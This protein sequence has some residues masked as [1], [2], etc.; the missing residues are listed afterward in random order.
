[1]S[2]TPKKSP[3]Q[4]PP[5]SGIGAGAPSS[6][7]RSSFRRLSDTSQRLGQTLEALGDREERADERLARCVSRRNEL[8][9]EIADLSMQLSAL[10]AANDARAA[11]LDIARS[12]GARRQR[13]IEELEAEQAKLRERID[14]T[15]AATRQQQRQQQQTELPDRHPPSPLCA[16][17]AVSVAVVS[18]VFALSSAWTVW[19]YREDMSPRPLPS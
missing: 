15:A 5:G 14:A 2:Q 1:M 11:R 4:R 19:S 8:E 18:M 12:E 17:V 3:Q 9:H 6:A 13:R 10:T 16:I 7:K